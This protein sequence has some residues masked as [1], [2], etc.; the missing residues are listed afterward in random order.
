MSE[1]FQ[2]KSIPDYRTRR[3]PRPSGVKGMIGMTLQEMITAA[4]GKVTAAKA[5][6][7]EAKIA[8]AEAELSAL[9]NVQSA[10]YVHTQG[11]IDSAVTNRLPDA[12]NSAKEAER[13]ALAQKLGVPVEKL[14]EELDRMEQERRSGQSEVQRLSTDLASRDQELATERTS[15]EQ[16]QKTAETAREQLERTLINNAITTEL[17]KA[18]VIHGEEESYLEGARNLTKT[19]EVT[20][21]TEIDA[22]GNLKIKGE[23]QGAKEA[24]ENTRETY[25]VMFGD[26]VETPIET[27]HG[28]KGGRQQKQ[29]QG[30][31]KPNYS[32]TGPQVTG[33]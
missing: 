32:I 21:E 13:K 19:D 28:N 26:V 3:G 17:I 25:P 22:D 5:D 1:N 6:G 14:D 31:Y 12:Q 29:G 30:N 10:G 27:P 4:Q 9:Q 20:V 7:D 2:G 24:A 33:G 11:D 8:A 15:R 18:G 23:V 16:A